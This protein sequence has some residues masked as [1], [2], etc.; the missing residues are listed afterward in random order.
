[1]KTKHIEV[2][3]H[4]IRELITKKKLEDSNIDTEVNIADC[5]TKPLP[6]LRFGA[7]GTKT[8]IGLRQ[9]I[10]KNRAEE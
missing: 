7:L 8:K 6:D 4:N 2:Q 10:E 5:L 3:F 9:A 1:M